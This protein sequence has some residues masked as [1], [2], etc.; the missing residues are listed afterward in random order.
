M[1]CSIDARLRKYEDTVCILTG[2]VPRSA[3]E[4]HVFET[5]RTQRCWIWAGPATIKPGRAVFN[6]VG[7][8]T[9][10]PRKFTWRIET[11]NIEISKS[12]IDMGT[13]PNEF[14]HSYIHL[15]D[16]AVKTEEDPTGTAVTGMVLGT[17]LGGSGSDQQNLF[18]ASSITQPEY[19]ALE[20]KIYECLK[21]GKA[22]IAQLEWQFKYQTDERTRPYA[23]WYHA[24]FSGEHNTPSSC[25]N[26]DLHINN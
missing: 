19:H 14:S 26:I 5:T 3:H 7:V 9:D 10:S 23:I 1:V 18:P 22:H 15:L 20:D 4:A 17:K 13:E 8:P 16:D 2:S 12:H 24:R 6:V 11:A 25:A 21:S